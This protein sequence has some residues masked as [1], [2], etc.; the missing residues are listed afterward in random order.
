MSII[1]DN[2][3]YAY[4]CGTPYETLALDHVHLE[5]QDGEYLG[6]MGRTGCGKSTLIQL[7]AGLLEPL[8]G[9]ILLNNEDIN[10]KRYNRNKLR[11]TI[12]IVFQ[13][14]EYQLFESTVEKDVSFGLKHYELSKDEVNNRVRSAIE[15]VGFEFEEVKALSP[16]SLS[17]GEKRRIAIA[18]VLAMQ[19]S[20]LIF[21]EPIAG[22]DP[23]GRDEFLRLIDQLHANGVTIIMV[24]HNIDIIFEHAKRLLILDT[25]TLAFDGLI[26][27]AMEHPEFLIQTGVGVSQTYEVAR[28][29]HSYD[30]I[31]PKNIYNYDEMILALTAYGKRRF[32]H[33]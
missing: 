32:E 13:F 2:L 17:G 15:F 22:L 23:S 30:T 8:N 3:S 7:M 16:F 4:A 6:I 24:S 18:G 31:F 29:M 25:G 27:E 21:D 33:E 5:I 11:Q 10:D 1:I 9:T 26:E 12:G 20:I 28:F 14:P 19:P